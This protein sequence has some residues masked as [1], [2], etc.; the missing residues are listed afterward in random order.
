LASDLLQLLDLASD[1][2]DKLLDVGSQLILASSDL[3]DLPL[4][5][6]ETSGQRYDHYLILDDFQNLFSAK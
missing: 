2:G 1:A 3:A 5:V 6:F 4:Q